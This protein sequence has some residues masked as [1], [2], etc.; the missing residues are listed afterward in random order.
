MKL[1]FLFLSL[2]KTGSEKDSSLFFPNPGKQA[3]RKQLR[4]FLILA[5]HR[6]RGHASIRLGWGERTLMNREVLLGPICNQLSKGDE[7]EFFPFFLTKTGSEKD[8]SLFFP[9]SGKQAIRKQLRPLLSLLAIEN[10]AMLRFIWA[11]EKDP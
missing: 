3:I 7:T 10:V 9:N 1:N 5:R 6:K 4:F 11:G 8:S 2:T